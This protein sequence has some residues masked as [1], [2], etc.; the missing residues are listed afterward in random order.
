MNLAF[1]TDRFRYLRGLDDTKARRWDQRHSSESDPRALFS[2]S[3][4]RR[5]CWR[6]QA[7]LGHYDD[8]VRIQN[9]FA[10]PFLEAVL[11]PDSCQ[12][13]RLKSRKSLVILSPGW[14]RGA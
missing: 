8:H 1:A 6:S 14:V 12:I 13:L 11:S 9:A 10:E 4:R 5:G 3:H 2:T 7:H